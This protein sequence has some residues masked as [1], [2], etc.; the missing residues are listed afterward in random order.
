[1]RHGWHEAGMQTPYRKETV[2]PS[3][4]TIHTLLLHDLFK[5]Y[6][7]LFKEDAQVIWPALSKETNSDH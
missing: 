5:Y 6:S 4:R 2:V 1:M 3:S 7:L